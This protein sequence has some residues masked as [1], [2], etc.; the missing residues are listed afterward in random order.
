MPA[1]FF[2]PFVNQ[3]HSEAGREYRSMET[4]AAGHA[5]T[6]AFSRPVYGDESWVSIVVDYGSIPANG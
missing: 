2:L 5:G 3:G 1:A 6:L 4:Y